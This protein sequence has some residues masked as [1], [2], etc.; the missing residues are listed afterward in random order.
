M[1]WKSAPSIPMSRTLGENWPAR[2]ALSLR[3]QPPTQ[4][5]ARVRR[6]SRRANLFIA[7]KAG[8]RE[9]SRRDLIGLGDEADRVPNKGAGR[10]AQKL[11]RVPVQTSL[12]S[13]FDV[14]AGLDPARVDQCTSSPVRGTATGNSR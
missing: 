12:N 6:A 10:R 1:I 7:E 4:I 8:P 14:G 3:E 13:G 5:K 11:A 2:F 9:N